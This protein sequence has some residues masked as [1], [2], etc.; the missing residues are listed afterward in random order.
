[1]ASRQVG[2]S[3]V[4]GAIAL[5]TVL[6]TAGSW[7]LILSASE[8][9]AKEFF[10]VNVAGLWRRLGKPVPGEETATALHLA[11]GSRVLAL[12]ENE[13]T[14]RVYSGVALLVVD[15]AARVSDSL[16]F[17]VRPML[18]VSRGRLLALS[19][20]FGRR[21]WFYEEWIGSNRWHRVR[22]PA[23]QCP[24]LTKEFLAEEERSIGQRWFRQEFLCSF[25]DVVGAVFNAEDVH[26]ALSGK[27]APLFGV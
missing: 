15:E 12:P 9:Q 20:P 4:A 13:R 2:K 24:R 5:V 17:T 26:A 19:T 25:E 23:D 8:R 16:Y 3:V 22:V 6:L 21:G 7:V 18:S 27:V 11:N 14:V 1:L 10:A